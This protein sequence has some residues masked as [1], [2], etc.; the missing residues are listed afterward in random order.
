M[1][2]RKRAPR[3]KS[4]LKAAWKRK[5]KPRKASAL[6]RQTEQN[7]K[8]IKELK[9]SREL[10]YAR[11]GVAKSANNFIGQILVKQK[12][13]NYGLTQDSQTWVANAGQQYLSAALAALYQPLWVCPTVITMGQGVLA[14][15]RIGDD[16]TMVS[17]NIKGT[18]TGGASIDNGGIYKGMPHKQTLHMY[19]LLDK[20][21]N[22][23]NTSNPAIYDIKFTPGQTFN[24]QSQWND[25]LPAGF[26]T[27][28]FRGITDH[29]KSV[30]N[31]DKMPSGLPTTNASRDL[32]NQS[33]WSKDEGG[34]SEKD[35]F[36]VLKHFKY[37]CN[38]QR[39]ETGT[40]AGPTGQTINT[41]PADRDQRDFSETIKGNYKFHFANSKTTKPDNQ[42]IHLVFVSETPTV[43]YSVD[44]GVGH[45]PENFVTAPSVTLNCSFNYTDA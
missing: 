10:K 16:V 29:L 39:A 12:V 32:L 13:D 37:S 7:R 14:S 5:R 44:D 8:A 26:S 18:M 2:R 27:A 9:E 28:D 35:R 4:G 11:T 1:F 19:V 30:T 22:P 33:Y 31:G 17:L 38:Q 3:R 40:G 34:I 36:K 25:S 41:L 24:Y 42:C 45:A 21:P 6:V 20:N 23:E 15:Q 43:R